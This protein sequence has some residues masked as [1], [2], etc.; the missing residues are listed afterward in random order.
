[1]F[2]QLLKDE[3]IENSIKSIEAEILEIEKQDDSCMCI[4]SCIFS[5]II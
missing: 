4:F 2:V 5:I 1:M 3:C